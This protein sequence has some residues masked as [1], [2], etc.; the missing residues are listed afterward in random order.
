VLAQAM[1]L[2]WRQGYNATSIRDLTAHVGIS[3]SSLYETYTDKRTLY[4]M[5]LAAF[6]EMELNTIQAQLAEA[7]SAQE[8]MQAWFEETIHNLLADD[9]YRGSFTVNAAIV[10]K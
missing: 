6:R 5:A 9:H 4:L 10:P 7:T 1:D 3:S 2:F 8:T